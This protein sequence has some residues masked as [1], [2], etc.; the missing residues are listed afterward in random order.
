M[1]K[2]HGF[3]NVSN[4]A[5]TTFC[6]QFLMLLLTARPLSLLLSPVLV[7]ADDISHGRTIKPRKRSSCDSQKSSS[8]SSLSEKDNTRRKAWKLKREELCKSVF[9]HKQKCYTK[10]FMMK[11]DGAKSKPVKVTLKLYANGIESDTNNSMTMGV[12][13]TAEEVQVR[14]TAM[15]NLTLLTRMGPEEQEE[16][17]SSKEVRESLGNFVIYDFMPHEVL[18]RCHSKYVEIVPSVHLTFDKYSCAD[19]RV[20]KEDGSTDGFVAN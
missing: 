5:V 7:H 20:P 14:D 19:G 8:E 2:I 9:S 11:V 4:S 6:V 3:Q 18:K 15:L 10:D 12:L 1:V 16:F 17:I 13:V